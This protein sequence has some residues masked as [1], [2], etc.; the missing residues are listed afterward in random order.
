MFSWQKSSAALFFAAALAACATPQ[1][2]LPVASPEQVEPQTQAVMQLAVADALAREERVR[3]LAFPILEENAELCHKTGPLMGWRIGDAETVQSL[4]KG[5]KKH[6]VTAL[7]WDETPRLLSIAPGS[8]AEAAGLQVGDRL[9]GLAESQDEAETL[10]DLGKM[11]GKALQDWEDGDTITVAASRDGERFETELTPVEACKVRVVSS[12][13]NSINAHATTNTIAM[14]AGLL[15]VF[16]DDNDVAFVIAHELAHVSQRH[17][18]KGI[19]NSFATGVVLWGPPSYLLAGAFDWLTEWPAEKLGAQSPPL[20]TLVAQ[21][22][23]S[24]VGS[25]GFEREADY[26][27]LYMHV[28]AGRSPDGLENVFETF[29]TVSPRTS[30]LKVSHPVVPERL[31]HLQQTAEE[32][33]AKQAAGEP[34]IPEGLTVE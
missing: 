23:S 17:V 12:A 27:G 7:G 10:R 18:R 6:H 34:L 5:L 28:R 33:R 16:P 26:I 24:S 19:R 13:S 25:V 15:R 22:A 31:L 11:L 2:R 32:I 21:A 3:R 30:W 9:I 8:P 4:A 20:T 1:A 29:G 14:Y